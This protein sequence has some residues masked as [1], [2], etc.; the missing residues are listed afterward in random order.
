MPPAKDGSKKK[1]PM[2]HL[3]AGGCAGFVESSVCHPLD[4]IKTRMQLRRQDASV[5]KVVVRVRN[6]LMEPAL[7]LQHSLRDPAAYMPSTATLGGG[8]HEPGLHLGGGPLKSPQTTVVIKPLAAASSTHPAKGNVVRAGLGPWGTARRVVQREGFLALYKGLSAVYTGIVPKMAIRF[9]SFEQYRDLLGTA[10]GATGAGVT[11]T[12]GLLSGL[13]E[14][15]MIV[16]PAEV[17]KIR[18]QGQYHSMM[19]P[20]QRLH[21][22]YTNVFQTAV[23]ITR[24]EGVGALYK[25]LVPTMLRQGCNQ[26]VNF[27]AY[28]IIKRKVM[29]WQHSDQLHHWQSLMIGGLSGGMG[30]LGTW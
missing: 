13:T 15:I 23:T 8:V 1:H 2:L 7:R 12:A 28:S 10:T 30:P 29:E 6:S 18:M 4:T 5:E 27:T 22:K 25:G 24:E 17:C 14:A 26:A 11:F 3:V 20:T 21:R 19:D 9:V 16:T